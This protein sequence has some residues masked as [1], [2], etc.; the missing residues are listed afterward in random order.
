[1]CCSY[2]YCLFSLM[3]TS[4]FI[5]A[6]FDLY[7]ICMWLIIF[8]I[9]IQIVFSGLSVLSLQYVTAKL[10]AEIVMDIKK[11]VLQISVKSTATT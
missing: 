4:S 5:F 1:M 8:L 6:I 11:V 3:F 9:A 7:L 2:I 10:L